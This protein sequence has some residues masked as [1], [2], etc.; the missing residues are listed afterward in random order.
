MSASTHTAMPKDMHRAGTVFYDSSCPFCVE[1]A[2]RFESVLE[3]C[4]FCLMPLQTSGTAARLGIGSDELLTEMRLQLQDG[5]VYGGADGVTQIARRIWWG[6]PL[7]AVSRL[8]G[9]MP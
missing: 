6:W 8:P 7:W 4:G 3:R 2:R 9:A 5:T 1:A